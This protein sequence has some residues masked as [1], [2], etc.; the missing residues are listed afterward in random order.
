MST[1]SQIKTELESLGD[2]EKREKLQRYFKTGKGEYG[3]GDIFLGISVGELRRIAKRYR[4]LALPMVVKLLQNKIH[5]HRQVALLILVEKFKKG[6]QEEREKIVEIY[7]NNT[8]WINNWD[9]K[10]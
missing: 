8:R 7:L 9:L 5:E 2:P 10:S 3:E 6:D 4:E 1:L